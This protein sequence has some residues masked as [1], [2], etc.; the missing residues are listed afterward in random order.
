MTNAFG[1]ITKIVLRVSWGADMGFNWSA[2]NKGQ[3]LGSMKTKVAVLTVIGPV[4]IGSVFPSDLALH[5]FG[6]NLLEGNNPDL[7]FEWFVA[8]KNSWGH[9]YP[10]SKNTQVYGLDAAILP[11]LSANHPSVDHG[12]MLNYLVAQVPDAFRFILV[13]DPDCFLLGPSALQK[14]LAWIAENGIGFSGTP[15]GL[16]FPKSFFRD[17]P[18]VFA[19]IIDQ[20]LVDVKDLDFMPNPLELSMVS[21][22]QKQNIWNFPR[23]IGT[24]IRSFL[25]GLVA[26]WLKWI[27]GVGNPTLWWGFLIACRLVPYDGHQANDTSSQVRRHF[28][29]STNHF[30]LKVVVHRGSLSESTS[31]SIV[32]HRKNSNPD[33]GSAEYFRNHGVFEGWTLN[34]G[35]IRDA[36][37]QRVALM[38]SAGR[39]LENN[40]FPTSSLVFSEELSDAVQIEKLCNSFPGLDLWVNED[41]IFAIHLGLPTKSGLVSSGSWDHL[42]KEIMELNSNS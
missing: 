32:A 24:K 9:E 29:K 13:L 42:K 15:Y 19:M 16:G 8:F 23:S 3:E 18:T 22:T 26:P 33:F 10:N 40:R 39:P 28:L 12:A 37:V 1:A 41:S 4:R 31:Q 11:E 6:R 17:F 27:F 7:E 38:F 30:E 36:L 21:T 25:R 35:G 5:T 14:H 2:G 34:K 20:T